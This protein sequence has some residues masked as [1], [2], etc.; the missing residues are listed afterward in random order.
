V[1]EFELRLTL[2][3]GKYH[4]VKRMLAAVGNRVEGLHRSQIGNL[5]LPADLTPGQWR[6]LTAPDLASIAGT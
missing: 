2:T 4:Q 1:D 5:A 6:W 3:E